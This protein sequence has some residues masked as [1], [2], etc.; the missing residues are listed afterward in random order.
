MVIENSLLEYNRLRDLNDMHVGSFSLLP[1]PI[2]QG[3]FSFSRILFFLWWS[4]IRSEWS[5]FRSRCLDPDIRCFV[6]FSRLHRIY[7]VKLM[8]QQYRYLHFCV[9]IRAVGCKVC[10]F[11]AFYDNPNTHPHTHTHTLSLTHTP[12]LSH[13]HTLTQPDMKD[14]LTIWLWVTKFDPSVLNI[15]ITS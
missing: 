14:W 1:A 6:V 7:F 8:T 5:I 12:S 11:Q 3:T 4:R 13:T 9:W 15:G 2:F 10:G